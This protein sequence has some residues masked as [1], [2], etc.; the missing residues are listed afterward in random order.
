MYKAY[1]LIEMFELKFYWIACIL[2]DID[3][4]LVQFTHQW[5]D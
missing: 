3:L 5:T 2:R 4:G 1:I